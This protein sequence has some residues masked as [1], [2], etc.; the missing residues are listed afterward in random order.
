MKPNLIVIAGPTASGKTGAS[1]SLAKVLDCQIISCDSRQFYKEVPVGTAAPT[2][3]EQDGVIHHFIGNKS[4][5]EPYSAGDYETDCLALIET[6]FKTKN[7]VILVGGSGLFVN[8]VCNGLDEFPEI[9]PKIREGL[10]T[11][12]EQQGI[13]YLQRLLQEKDPSY[14][15]EVDINNQQRLIRALEVSIGTNKPFSSFRKK[16]PKERPFNIIKV[17]IDWPREALY[18]R[19]NSRV[20]RMM[21]QGLLEEAKSVLPYRNHNAL[22]TVGYKELFHY[23]DGAWDL[24][25]AVSEIQKNSR[26]YA[27]RQLTWFKRDAT[28]QWFAPNSTDSMQKYIHSKIHS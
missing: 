25:T 21:D 14:F 18:E 26:R 12:F 22:Q 27:K 28:I 4:I 5:T 24:E 23:F 3:E 2:L 13:E 8:A 17:G 10:I 7:N 20:H 15:K 16:S 1:I 19:I 9:D 11:N 6:L